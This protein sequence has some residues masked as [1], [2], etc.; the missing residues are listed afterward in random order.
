MGQSSSKP[1]PSSTQ[2]VFASET[3][4]RFSQELVDALQASP[5]TDS[6][7]AKDLELHIQS[8][9]AAELSRLEAEQSRALRELEEKISN[10]PDTS[11]ESAH[12]PSTT[13]PDQSESAGG[14]DHKAKKEGD[15][16]RDL[17]RESVM[18]EIETLRRALGERKIREEVDAD[19]GV[20]KAKE[21]VV[22]CLR[23]NDRRPLDCWRE[24]EAFKREVGRLEKGFVERVVG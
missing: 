7:R 11:T 8:R 20:K 17:G 19:R 18:K 9:V 4:V 16:R 2:H 22:Q 12:A 6:T 10:T 21:E 24:V 5:E 15:K 3:P 13:M 1:P 23:I 14:V